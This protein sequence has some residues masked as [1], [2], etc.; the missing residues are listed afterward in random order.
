MI[1]DLDDDFHQPKCIVEELN[2]AKGTVYIWMNNSHVMR[3]AKP[4]QFLSANLPVRSY[5][6]QA[7]ILTPAYGA[8]VLCI[9]H[10]HQLRDFK[11]IA[12]Y[13]HYCHSNSQFSGVNSNSGSGSGLTANRWWSVL[14]LPLYR[15]QP[16]R[17]SLF[18]RPDVPVPV[19]ELLQSD[20]ARFVLPFETGTHRSLHHS[21]T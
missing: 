17:S 12:R 10:K 2:D 6:I 3:A 4:L 1:K 11:L 15:T 9:V 20:V 19:P 16:I 18:W 21:G 7:I 8:P 14:V 5:I 13:T